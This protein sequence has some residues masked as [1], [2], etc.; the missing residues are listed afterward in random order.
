MRNGK[1]ENVQPLDRASQ[2]QQRVNDI[3]SALRRNRL[4]ADQGTVISLDPNGKDDTLK[5][6]VLPR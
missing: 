1:V 3:Q 2:S 6:L 4:I 5:K